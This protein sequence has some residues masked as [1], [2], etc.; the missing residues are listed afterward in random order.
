ML[1]NKSIVVSL[2]SLISISALATNKDQN[3]S[4]FSI[5]FLYLNASNKVSGFTVCSK[6]G[7]TPSTLSD[8]DKFLDKLNK[9]DSVCVSYNVGTIYRTSRL[10]YF[11]K[12]NTNGNNRIEFISSNI[13][14]NLALSNYPIYKVT[15]GESYLAHSQYTNGLLPCANWDF[16]K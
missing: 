10:D 3:D 4:N 7:C 6:N 8:G 1:L 11:F 12:I 2:L 5:H 15:E 13:S 14:L 16:T 9:G